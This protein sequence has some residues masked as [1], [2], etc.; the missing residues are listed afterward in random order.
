ML[1]VD[2]GLT[3]IIGKQTS[4][5][6][7][8]ISVNYSDFQHVNSLSETESIL[9]EYASVFDTPV[10]CFDSTTKLVTK[11]GTVPVNCKAARIPYTLRKRVKTE[12]EHL[13]SIGVISPVNTPTEWSSRM[14][15][16]TKPSGGLRICIDSRELN[17]A[18]EKEH[19][20]LPVME[21][22]LPSLSKARVF[23]E[24]DVSSALALQ[25]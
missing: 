12:L 3:P 9:E 8:I 1:V 14:V 10:G 21:D 16:A 23:T 4:E 24:L 25:T 7:G 20:Q 22:I 19:Y 17:K 15:V 11:P 5:K 13:Q 2:K 18:I 6:M